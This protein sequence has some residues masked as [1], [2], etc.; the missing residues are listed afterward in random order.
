MSDQEKI[1]FVYQTDHHEGP[2]SVEEVAGKAKQGLV[3]SQTLAWRDGMAE[4]VAAES[5]PD[6]RPVFGAAAA[7]E[8]E[9]PGEGEF[10]AM[11]SQ[12]APT[13]LASLVSQATPAA[14]PPDESEP[15]PEE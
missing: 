9:S 15:G 13:A 12:G 6:L 4:W 7:P 5:I 11:K 3:T 8:A 2:F 14:A 10:S 1:W